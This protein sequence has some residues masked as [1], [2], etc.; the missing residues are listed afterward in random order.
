MISTLEILCSLF[1]AAYTSKVWVTK[2]LKIIIVGRLP[3]SGE[4]ILL[5]VSRPLFGS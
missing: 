1:R 4:Y 5:Y 2:Y 3:N